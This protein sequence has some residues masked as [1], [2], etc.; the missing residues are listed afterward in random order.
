MSIFGIYLSTKTIGVIF[1]LICVCLFIG[2]LKDSL[3]SEVTKFTP[4][5]LNK[6]LKVTNKLNER[7][8]E[9]IV[10]SK[11]NMQTKKLCKI[12]RRLRIFLYSESTKE[13][14]VEL[15]ERLNVKDS[16]G[17]K[18]VPDELYV[19]SCNNVIALVCT[20]IMLVVSGQLLNVKWI[21]AFGVFLAVLIPVVYRAPLTKLRKMKKKNLI[22][23]D[24]DMI[25]F[26]NMFYY[27][28][29]N[30]N[31]N[32]NLDDL[33]DSFLPL[34]NP[35]M[36][37]MLVRFQLDINGLGDEAALNILQKQYGD[38][39]YVN[40]F[41]NVALGLLEKHSNAYV[42]LDSLFERLN[43]ISRLKYKKVCE[44]KHKKKKN[45]YRIILGIFC[46]EML[47]FIVFQIMAIN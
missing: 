25:E 32:F 15:I 16:Y 19:E 22:K 47:V 39:T 14:Y 38:S 34:A 18:V 4:S 41:C 9:N 21:D 28:F 6:V 35:E 37:R 23:I 12:Y 31:I 8:E 43:T 42:Q 44:L 20:C 17:Y 11:K 36:S 46:L 45:A 30:R 3:M 24:N 26:I 2:L 27:R 29:S 33:I 5:E 7:R 40:I 1:L 10:L 13:E